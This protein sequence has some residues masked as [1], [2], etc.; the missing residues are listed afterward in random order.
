M[1][2]KSNTEGTGSLLKIFGV[3]FGLAAVVGGMVGQ[4]I[5]RTPGIVAGAVHSPELILLLWV[6]GGALIAISALAYIELGTSM[7]SAGGPLEFARRAF[8]F[9]AGTAAGWA[10]WLVIVTTTSFLTIVVAEFLH[11]LGVFVD[12]P[13]SLIALSVLILFWGVNWVGARFSGD[14]QVLFSAF[15]GAALIAFVILLFANPSEGTHVTQPIG[16]AHALGIAA[17]AT[18]VRAIINTYD[19]WQDL[20]LFSEEMSDPARTLPRAML[21]GIF[22]VVV[23]YFFVNMALLQVLTP[24]Q[25]ADS[26]LPAATATEVVLGEYGATALT[27]FGVI[28]VAAIANATIMKSARITFALAREGLLPKSF[29]K[30]SKSGTPRNALAASVAVAACFVVTGTYSSVVAMN[31]ALGV[32]LVI[33]VN[34]AVVRLRIKEPA[35][36]RPFKVPLYPLPILVGV[37]VNTCLV[38]AL[39]FDDPVNSATG[40]LVLAILGLGYWAGRHMRGR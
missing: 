31:V 9:A 5:L 10:A 8:G 11:Q 18:A 28:S 7:P 35:L 13:V 14:S 21:Y 20:V 27:I 32:S 6:L 23:L 38:V 39:F 29:C 24:A 2:D 25:I 19:G 34:L 17:I 4:G 37:V 36:D 16:P 26:K 1:S 15:K 12:V 33:L 40:F 22:G 3:V 30:V